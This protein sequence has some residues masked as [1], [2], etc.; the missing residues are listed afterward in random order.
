MGQS[1][2]RIGM[3]MPGTETR[4]GRAGKRL[5]GQ[6]NKQFRRRDLR[7]AASHQ[8]VEHREPTFVSRVRKRPFAEESSLKLG[9]T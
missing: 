5:F 2:G 3:V 7:L 1:C 9:T 8:R 6:Q 4:Q